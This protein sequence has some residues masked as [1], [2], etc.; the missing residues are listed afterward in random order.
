MAVAQ[1]FCHQQRPQHSLASKPLSAPATSDSEV[2]DSEP[3]DSTISK[4]LSCKLR[5]QALVC[6]ASVFVVSHSL[7][8][9]TFP[10][11]QSSL[12]T[13]DCWS[14]QHLCL[15]VVIPP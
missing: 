15:L 14:S 7:S 4:A 1:S 11:Q 10:Q 13:A 2:S 12:T 5:H 8:Q 6:L 3:Q 9:H